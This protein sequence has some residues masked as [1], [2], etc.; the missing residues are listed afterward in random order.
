[1]FCTRCGAELPD[2]AK[3]CI[4]CGTP[5]ARV[6]SQTSM[7]EEPEVPVVPPPEPTVPTYYVPESEPAPTKPKRS[8]WPVLILSLL[9]VLLAAICVVLLVPGVHDMVFGVEPVSFIESST[10]LALGDKRDLTDLLDA[11]ERSDED[12]RWSSD[13]EQVASVKN[14]VVT[15]AGEGSCVITV[16][17]GKHD[18]VSDTIR[19]TVYEKKLGFRSDSLTLKAGET[20]KLADGNLFYEHLDP[21]GLRWTTSNDSVALVSSSGVVTAVSDGTAFITVEVDGLKATVSVT[22]EA[23][24]PSPTPGTAPD[25]A[26]IR[27]DVEQIRGWYYQPGSKDVR[28][29]IEPGT[30]GWDYGREYLYHDG[31]MV[32]AFLYTDTEQYRLYFKDRIL[33]Y[34]IETDRTERSGDEM[35]PYLGLADQARSDALNHAP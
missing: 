18:A 29:D 16:R 21:S 20:E 28:R 27:R 6:H 31:E 34:V 2:E 17:D 26:S 22:V 7:R 5:V 13:N 10:E 9:L 3:S 12:L 24:A 19:V 4:V 35:I 23:V 14:G 32:F 11:G 25:D 15:A 8:V 33:I 1:M 30:D